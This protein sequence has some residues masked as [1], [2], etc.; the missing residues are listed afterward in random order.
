M[1]Y[2][3]LPNVAFGVSEWQSGMHLLEIRRT[4]KYTEQFMRKKCPRTKRKEERLK[5]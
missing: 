4:T 1:H 2:S 5:Q 3:E